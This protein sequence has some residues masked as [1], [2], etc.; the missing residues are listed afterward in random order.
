MEIS[1]TI[2]MLANIR[3][4]IDTWVPHRT[5]RP[6]ALIADLNDA[7]VASTQNRSMD[8]FFAYDDVGSPS[9][10]LRAGIEAEFDLQMVVKNL[11]HVFPSLP[12]PSAN[13]VPYFDLFCFHAGRDRYNGENVR[14]YAFFPRS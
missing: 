4:S 11:R 2:Q 14:V 13:I 3:Q 1:D 6:E 8:E 9:L 5:A 10:T 7:D 12:D